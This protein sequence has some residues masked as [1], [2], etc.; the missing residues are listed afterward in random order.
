MSR[1]L[2]LLSV[3]LSTL[4]GC[5]TG[6]KVPFFVEASNQTLA[7]PP[8]D[9]AQIVFLEPFNSIGSNIPVGIFD[10]TGGGRTMIGAT[11]AHSKIAVLFTPGHHLLVDNPGGNA[12]YLD[13]N[14]EA[15]KRYYVLMRFIYGNGFQMRPL[16]P[17]GS[18]D[19]TVLNK[20][21]PAWIS[22]SQFVE[23][24]ASTDSFYERFK[25]SMIKTEAESWKSWLNKT[26]QER[27]EL[28]LNPQDAIPL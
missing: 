9:K 16:R 12:H 27:E 13:V 2:V 22:E 8:S 18:S 4:I 21:F 24:T 17:S 23:K 11:T 1:R 3:L 28:T 20:S 5:A 14:V 6:P 26:P 7:P 19:Y 25:D 15:G 10:V